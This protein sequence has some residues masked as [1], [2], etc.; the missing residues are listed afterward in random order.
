MIDTLILILSSGKKKMQEKLN[1][2]WILKLDPD[3][4]YVQSESDFIS[5]NSMNTL[6][7]KTP[8]L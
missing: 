2:I 7:S 4:I 1:I 3:P 5:K 6:R 8:L